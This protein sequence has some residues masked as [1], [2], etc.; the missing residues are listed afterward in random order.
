M[1]LN[2]SIKRASTVNS[3]SEGVLTHLK[4]ILAQHAWEGLR[5]HI[6]STGELLHRPTRPTPA[7][8]RNPNANYRLTAVSGRTQCPA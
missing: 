1:L 4:T 5:R 2:S 7:H 6:A 3:W 8:R